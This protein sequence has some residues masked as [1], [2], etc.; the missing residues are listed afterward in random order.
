MPAGSITKAI[1]LLVIG[2][3]LAVGSDVFVKVMGEDVPIFQFIFLR[4]LL[5]L[6]VLLPL[7][8]RFDLV[9]PFDGL[10]VHAFRSLA[11]MAG[12]FCM[13]VALTSLPLATANAVFYVAPILVMLLAVVIFREKLTVLSVF[14]VFSGFAGIVVILRPVEFNWGALAALGGALALAI[15]AVMVRMLPTQQSTLHRLFLSYLLV[16]P[17]AAVL[18]IWEGLA[19]EPRVVVGAVG[20]GVL[21]LGYSITV[22][23]AYRDVD[24]NQV[25]SAEY[26]GLIWAVAIGWVWFAEVPDLWFVVGSLMIVVP[27]VWL[28]LDQRRRA[29]RYRLPE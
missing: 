8:R 9:T 24:A 14:A 19:L 6:L 26:T 28:G 4:S 17:V 11:G 1:V 18:F 7:Y 25:T 29:L 5:S 12:I 16:L 15:N 23:L 10:Y 21:I 20:S 22:L 27:L 13:V 2:N 3:A